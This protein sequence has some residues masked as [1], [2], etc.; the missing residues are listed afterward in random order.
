MEG[1]EGN[2]EDTWK[3]SEMVKSTLENAGIYMMKEEVER[4]MIKGKGKSRT[5]EK[6]MELWK[7]TTRKEQRYVM[8]NVSE[9]D[10]GKMEK[11]KDNR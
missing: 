1:K 8:K 3:I 9:G 2:W 7:E 5:R 10:E 4:W 6:S 11:R